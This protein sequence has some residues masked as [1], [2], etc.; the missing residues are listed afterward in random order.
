MRMKDL[1]LLA[2]RTLLALAAA[3]GSKEAR[4]RD[5]LRRQARRCVDGREPCRKVMLDGGAASQS[6][7]EDGRRT[8]PA[9]AE[10]E[11]RDVRELRRHGR[12][13]ART[14]SSTSR[15]DSAN[16]YFDAPTEPVKLDQQGCRYRPH[17][18]GIRTK[19]PLE[20]SNS[21]DT[22]HNVHAMPEANREFNVGQA[23]K[24][25]VERRTFTKREVMVP[26][27]CDVHGWM[28]AFVGVMDHPYFAVTHDGGKFELKNLPAGTYTVEAWHEKLGTQTQKVTI[29]EKQA[30]EVTFTFKVPRAAAQLIR[31][32]DELVTSIHEARGR[33]DGAAH[34]GRRHGHEHGLRAFRARLA[35]DVRL[36]DVLVSVQQVGRRDFLRAR[37]PADREHGRVS[38]HH[39]RRLDLAGRSE[40]MG[41]AARVRALGAVVLQGLLGGITVLLFLP[42]AVS[43]GHA[44]LAQ[45]FF[46]ITLSL[47]LFTSRGWREATVRG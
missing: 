28:H 40:S 13:P 24:H 11:R 37:P 35:D 39:P 29:A 21:D 9:R 38:H 41:A 15:T 20:I 44:A 12:R 14:C 22:M 45:L 33:G 47:A 5:R 30:A 16:Y 18:L 17:V 6:A 46:C 34:R 19:Q 26:F 43:I 1:R 36:V 3:C 23:I 10:P 31:Q 7:D 32:H 8:R 27:K 4:P 42:P 2:R 25:Q